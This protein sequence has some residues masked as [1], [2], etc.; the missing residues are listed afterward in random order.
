LRPKYLLSLIFCFAIR[1]YAQVSTANVVGVVQDSSNAS[2]PKA[3]VKLINIQTGTE[4]DSKTSINGGF[5]LPG[6]IPGA[7]TLQIERTGFATTQLNGI[8]LNVGDTKNLLIRMKVGSVSESVTVD[9]SGLTLNTTD[10][11]VSTLVDRKFV[12]NIPLNGRSFQDLISM[13][14]GVVT[15]SPQANGRGSGTQ[16]DFSVNG[17][18]LDA[19]SFFVD[20]VSANIN[21]GLTTGSS[22]FTIAGSSGGA[23]ALGTSQSLVSI[24]ALQE[25]RVLSSTYSAE[26]GR[27]PGGQFTFLTRSGT[28]TVHGS[29]FNYWQG[30]AFE[31]RD[32]FTSDLLRGFEIN[33]VPHYSQN[34][35]GGTMGAPI[36]IPGVYDGRDK[37]F[38]FLSSE[39]L[40]L[41]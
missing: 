31:A 16:G 27:T 8:N 23:T 29:L 22:R 1:L 7:Y 5:V 41:T 40:L 18:Q 6:V 13:T 3:S 24:D 21:S 4:N 28:N 26:Y 17:Q 32:W 34:D 15:Q 30:D 2:I 39:A 36:I 35:F 38:V 19:N 20:G 12:S 14:P 37:T 11:A 25:F 33:S 10:A 9:A